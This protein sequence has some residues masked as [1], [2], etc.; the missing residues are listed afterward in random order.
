M[1]P[2]YLSKI[3]YDEGVELKTRMDMRRLSFAGKAVAQALAYTEKEVKPG[4]TA[5]YLEEVCR[6]FL[7]REY[8]D[9]NPAHPEEFPHFLS[10]SVNEAAVHGLP[11]KRKLK[12]GDVVTL[13]LAAKLDG[14]Y[15]DCAVSVPVGTVAPEA[16]RLIEAGRRASEA[17]IAAVRSGG[18]RL[19]DIGSAIGEVLDELG[20]RVIENLAGHGVGRKIHEAPTVLNSGEAGV[21]AP[22]VP[23]MVFTVEPVVTAGKP[24]VVP[25][26]DGYGLVTEDGFPT[27]LFEHTIAVTS[28]GLRVLT[29]E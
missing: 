22:I 19:G 7:F 14:W 13:D 5:L 16:M 28:E 25:S 26:G 24:I 18:G 15:G 12:S 9:S 27:A 2:T 23:G 1:N 11:D 21:G 29:E 4:V 17:G 8:G 6:T 20:F 10:V 3:P